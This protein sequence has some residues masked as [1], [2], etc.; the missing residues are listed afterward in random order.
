MFIGKKQE[1][2]PL[3]MEAADIKRRLDYNLNRHI[4]PCVY[5]TNATHRT[6]LIFFTPAPEVIS[7]FESELTNACVMR[8]VLI[9]RVCHHLFP[10][11]PWM[12]CF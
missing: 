11:G 5:N 8:K 9:K 7:S 2:T 4:G 3:E 6:P 1:M 12:S 10:I